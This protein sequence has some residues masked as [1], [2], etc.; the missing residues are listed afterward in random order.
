MVHQRH[1]Y[2][3]SMTVPCYVGKS[4]QRD[5]VECLFYLQRQHAL[6]VGHQLD[7]GVVAVL[8]FENMLAQGAHEPL[9]LERKR[10]DFLHQESQF[11]DDIRHEIFCL[12]KMHG[13]AITMP[14][15]NATR[16]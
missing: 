14:V 7:G 13:H 6:V 15:E 11:L 5:P 2:T 8:P 10:V 1:I 4:L 16:G 12:G 9:L 3:S